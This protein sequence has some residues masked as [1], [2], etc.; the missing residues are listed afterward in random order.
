MR[1]HPEQEEFTLFGKNTD[2][3]CTEDD[4]I[5]LALCRNNIIFLIFNHEY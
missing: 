1:K 5:I 3:Y 4:F 2:Y